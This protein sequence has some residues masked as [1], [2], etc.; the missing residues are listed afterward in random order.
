MKIRFKTFTTYTEYDKVHGKYQV[1]ATAALNQ[2]LE[3]N[4]NIEIISWQTTSVDYITVQY[5]IWED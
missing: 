1:S 5:R 4:P 3:D 2:W